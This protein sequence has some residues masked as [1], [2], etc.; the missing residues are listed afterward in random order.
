LDGDHTKCSMVSY[1]QGQSDMMLTEG[2]VTYS[3]F[4][5]LI[6]FKV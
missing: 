6:S 5:V 2:E 3:Q 1:C 4:I